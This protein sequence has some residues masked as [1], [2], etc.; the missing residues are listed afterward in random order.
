MLANLYH[1]YVGHVLA[2]LAAAGID[3]IN[4]QSGDG[5]MHRGHPLFACFAGDYLEQ[6]LVTGVKTTQCPSCDVPSD[7]LGLAAGAASYQLQN[8]NAVLN[9]LS[10]LDEGG[11]A[12]V[13][14]CTEAG[15]KPIVHPYWEGLLF[16]NIFKSITPNILHQ[17]YQGLVKHL[18]TWLSD[19]CGSAEIDAR[20][21]CL[22][23]IT[24]SDIL[25][26]ASQHFRA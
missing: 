5:A 11:L 10:T 23:Q 1:A 25:W 15:I 26:R 18:L 21:H 13:H 3:G 20:C 22:P 6:V 24:T 16:V 9:A 17:L 12:F 14:A 19:P 2:P 7:E 8:L 4:I